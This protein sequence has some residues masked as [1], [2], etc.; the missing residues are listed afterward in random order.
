M[1]WPLRGRLWSFPWLEILTP[2]LAD[3]TSS[4]DYDLCPTAPPISSPIPPRSY[5][6]SRSN[7]FAKIGPKECLEAL[8]T[9]AILDKLAYASPHVFWRIVPIMFCNTIRM[10]ERIDCRGGNGGGGRGCLTWSSFDMWGELMSP[11]SGMV[12]PGR[13]NW[14]HQTCRICRTRSGDDCSSENIKVE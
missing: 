7:P 12:V 9:N 1:E 8:S 13:E 10:W 6:R 4:R 3:S 5:P 2:G 11:C 14:E